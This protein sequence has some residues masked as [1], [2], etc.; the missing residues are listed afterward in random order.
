MSTFVFRLP[1]LLL[2][3]GFFTFLWLPS[4]LAYSM[5]FMPASAQYK[6]CDS[7]SMAKPLGHVR[8]EEMI[9]MRFE[10]SIPARSIFGLAP[11]S[12]QYMNLKR[13]PDRSECPHFFTATTARQCYREARE[14]GAFRAQ[15]EETLDYSCTHVQPSVFVMYLRSYSNLYTFYC[16]WAGLITVC[17][18]K[19]KIIGQGLKMN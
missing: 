7:Q 2:K 6:R 15:Q 13:S 9:T 17:R 14:P 5:V 12:V 16:P 8:L 18:Q 11:Q 3:D 10:A 19:F 1:D 4:R